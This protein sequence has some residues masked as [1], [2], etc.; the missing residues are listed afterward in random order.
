MSGVPPAVG[1]G[2][3]TGEQYNPVI[4]TNSKP[5]LNII[6]DKATIPNRRRT[7][8]MFDELLSS[9]D[10]SYYLLRTWMA[11]GQTQHLA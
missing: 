8:R 1:G 9:R 6:P 3:A 4:S 5:L 7:Y 11:E 2:D 10:T